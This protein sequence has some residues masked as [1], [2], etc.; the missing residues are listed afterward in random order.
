VRQALNHAINRERINEQVYAGEAVIAQSLLPPGLLGYEDN[1]RGF[2][3]DRDRARSLMRAAGHGSGFTV[4]YR[5]WDTDE[6]N[7]SGLVALMIEDFEAIG[8][9]V[10][11]TRH[12]APEASGPRA[13][14]GHG[15]LYCANWYA[16]VPDSDNVFY[17][18]FH[19][20]A[21]SIRGLYFNRPEVDAQIMEARRSNDAAQRATIYRGLN[22][23][24]LQEAPIV[25]LFHERLFVLHKPDVRG[26][27]TS[28]VP[29]PVRYHDVW[30]ERSSE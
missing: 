16:D 12:S 15:L 13:R 22:Q 9:H 17:I 23:M 4:E 28:L 19:S 8:V 7:N 30:V 25:P 1:L 11:V 18:F 29:P 10:N 6:F 27:R 26:V 20:N 24:V 5:T 14:R 21:T 3:Y 2:D